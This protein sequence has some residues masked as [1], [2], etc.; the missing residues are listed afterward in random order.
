MINKEF[1][2][3][4][5]EMSGT[6]RVLY[7]YT[8][9]DNL[10]GIMKSGDL[11]PS[12]YEVNLATE[13]KHATGRVTDR[14]AEIATVRPSMA[15]RNNLK[16]LSANVGF[17]K[18]I[19]KPHILA[20]KVR[21]VR[22]KPIAEFPLDSI[23]RVRDEFIRLGHRNAQATQNA[24]KTLAFYRKLV[25]EGK[26]EDELEKEFTKWLRQMFHIEF[27]VRSMLDAGN[28][29]VYYL[30]NRE[31]EERISL[32]KTDSIPLNPVYL[33]IELLNGFIEDFEEGYI[34]KVDFSGQ[35]VLH[36][37][38]WK[39]WM[40][41]YDD[42]FIKNSIHEKFMNKLSSLEKEYGKSVVKISPKTTKVVKPIV[43]KENK[44]R[45]EKPIV[46]PKLKDL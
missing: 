34:E 13:K 8:N 26:T 3:F 11:K 40:E 10:A 7:H 24:N 33:S 22:T 17:V 44:T 2:N 23:D 4:L 41:K 37:A 35:E 6:P 5:S 27:P 21:G 25:D 20:D 29:M 16:D 14:V 12:D 43:K 32:K 45:T 19:I 1:K 31:G 9:T 38:Q 18:L 46:M 28:N 42:L 30:R 15:N 39:R 36:I